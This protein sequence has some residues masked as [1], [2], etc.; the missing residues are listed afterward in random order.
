MKKFSLLL[1]TLG[2]AMAGYVFSNN[3]LREQLSKA[4]D[5]EAAAKV[6]GKHLAQ[7]G[8]KLGAQIKE[9]VESDEVKQNL[10]KARK[11][12]KDSFE[13]AKKEVKAYVREQAGEVSMAIRKPKAFGK[14]R[15]V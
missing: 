11:Y 7:D 12:A 9:F 1:G 4:K 5:A 8:K 6:L 13:K 2:G 3:R 14:T 10:T 15:K